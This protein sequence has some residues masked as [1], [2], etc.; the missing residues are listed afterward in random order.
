MTT[1]MNNSGYMTFKLISNSVTQQVWIQKRVS[2]YKTKVKGIAK[3]K[4]LTGFTPG[5]G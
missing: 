4:K 1:T 3:K 5:N 2:L